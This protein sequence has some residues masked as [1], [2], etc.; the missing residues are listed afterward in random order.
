MGFSEYTEANDTSLIP[1]DTVPLVI[2][3]F[4]FGFSCTVWT[5]MRSFDGSLADGVLANAISIPPRPPIQPTYI[6]KGRGR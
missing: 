5:K 2:C 6:R 4:I 3:A 1:L